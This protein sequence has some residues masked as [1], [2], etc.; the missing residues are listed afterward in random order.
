MAEQSP[1]DVVNQAQSVGDPAPADVSADIATNSAASAAAAA[2]PAPTKPE[3]P[4]ES[5]PQNSTA[6]EEEKRTVEIPEDE[7]SPTPDG[8][9]SS[10]RAQ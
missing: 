1:R 10:P 2:T 5:S 7:P 4:L 3:I 9:V 8:L 6:V